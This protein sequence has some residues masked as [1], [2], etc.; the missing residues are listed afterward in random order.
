[1]ATDLDIGKIAAIPAA[2]IKKSRLPDTVRDDKAA[3]QSGRRQ[4][5]LCHSAKG[6]QHYSGLHSI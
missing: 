5:C 1:M 3:R 6:E 4:P 2:P